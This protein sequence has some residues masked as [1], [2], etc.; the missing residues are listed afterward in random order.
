MEKIK[1]PSYK[2]LWLAE[3]R[4]GD[5]RAIQVH[6]Y[7]DVLKMLKL[8]LLNPGSYASIPRIMFDCG[9][10]STKPATRDGVDE[11]DC[12]CAWG[13]EIMEVLKKTRKPD[14]K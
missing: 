4:E 14:G 5:L 10:L 1:R 9:H 12:Y 11:T 13:A 7:Q 6:G 2:K 3:E 8:E